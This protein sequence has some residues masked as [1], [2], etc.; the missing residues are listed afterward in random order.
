M[1]AG[2]MGCFS[3]LA[4]VL[5]TVGLYAMVSRWMG[6]R[7][8]EIG[9]RMALGA[10]P[11]NVMRLILRYGAGLAVWGIMAGMLVSSGVMRF[12]SRVLFG[13]SSTDVLT[14]TVIGLLLFLVALAACFVPARRAMRVDSMVALRHE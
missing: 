1:A 5:A 7:T 13:T 3:F 6:Q 14:V 4:L 11:R 9:I 10:D 8:R 12:A 2:I